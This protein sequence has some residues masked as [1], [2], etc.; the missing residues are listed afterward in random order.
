MAANE[1]RKQSFN[2]GGSR[3]RIDLVEN[4]Q[5]ARMLPQPVQYRLV[6]FDFFP[7]QLLRDIQNIRSA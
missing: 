3:F 5:P 6:L 2:R 1:L 4:Q 7:F